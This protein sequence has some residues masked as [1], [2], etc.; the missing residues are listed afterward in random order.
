MITMPPSAT[1]RIPGVMTTAELGS[2][3]QIGKNAV[4]RLVQRYGLREISGQSHSRRYGVHDIMRQILGVTP[5]A[6]EDLNLLLLPLQKA[7]WVARITG[8]SVSAINAA[9][10][11]NRL[12]LPAPVAL[13]QTAPGQAAPR[14]RRWIPAQIVA[15]LRGDPIPFLA[16]QAPLRGTPE[17][18]VQA[19]ARN[20][21]AAICSDTAEVSRQCQL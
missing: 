17:T 16:P 4:P 11:E 10:C 18:R 15:H 21:F 20:V 6:A 1:L 12:L 3:A 8:I 9:I 2:W 14:G 19:S 7:S 5:D 13:T